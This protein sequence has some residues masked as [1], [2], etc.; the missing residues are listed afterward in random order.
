MAYSL[1]P[2][3]VGGGLW[4]RVHTPN[5]FDGNSDQATILRHDIPLPLQAVALRLYPLAW[6]GALPKLRFEVYGC[7]MEE[8]D[9]MWSGLCRGAT[10]MADVWA[11]IALPL[12][13]GANAE[14]AGLAACQR[15]CRDLPA[16]TGFA[17]SDEDATCMLYRVPLRPLQP[18]THP[19]AYANYT[20][21]E[22]RHKL[23]SAQDPTASPMG[24]AP[25]SGAAVKFLSAPAPLQ[26]PATGK[27][28][29]H[30]SVSTPL[31]YTQAQTFAAAWGGRLAQ[32]QGIV[33]EGCALAAMEG[34]SHGAMSGI[35]RSVPGVVAPA[36][37]CREGVSFSDLQGT[38][39]RKVSV[40]YPSLG[41]ESDHDATCCALCLAESKCEFWV[42]TYTNTNAQTGT[43]WLRHSLSA[44]LTGA[45]ATERRSAYLVRYHDQV[46]SL[47]DDTKTQCASD[48]LAHD[49]K[50][51]ILQTVL[52]EG[53]DDALELDKDAACCFACR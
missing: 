11:N 44:R 6:S 26:C 9:P 42:R 35:I 18:W 22:A 46:V 29:R 24:T 39:I 45:S 43:C 38:T 28:F 51:S 23:V 25:I 52:L 5:E 17:W 48:G 47:G 27:I 41:S 2:D 8:Y 12:N 16:C 53:A 33:E 40:A 36:R 14:V 50:G 21:F 31:T 15:S 13:N 7:S 10:A 4:R 30:L 32:P 37:T 34:S 3:S 1:N 49:L 19:T 20:C